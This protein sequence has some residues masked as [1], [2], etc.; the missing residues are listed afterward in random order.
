MSNAFPWPPVRRVLMI[1]GAMAALAIFVYAWPTARNAFELYTVDTGSL[2]M[3]GAGTLILA[4]LL[5]IT[6]DVRAPSR[7]HARRV[8][9]RGEES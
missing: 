7:I 3:V 1:A 2:V 5:M 8:D 9:E 6:K 4:A